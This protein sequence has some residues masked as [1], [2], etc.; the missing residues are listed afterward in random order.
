MSARSFFRGDR[1]I[2]VGEI[3]KL[4]GAELHRNA[5]PARTITGIATLDRGGPSDLAFLDQA[6]DL[7]RA[8]ASAVGACLT[9]RH[10]AAC[11]P[12]H[13]ALLVVEQPFEAFVAV[14]RALFPDALRPS[15]LFSGAHA[16]PGVAAGAVVHPSA[17]LE[18]GVTIDPGAVIGAGAEVGS[19]TTIGANAVIGA[20]VRIGRNCA[21]GPNAS[22][23]H[24]LIG[25]R[26]I[27]H[28]GCRIGQDGFG[29]AMAPNGHLKIP[30]VGRVIVQDD[31]EIGAGSCIDRGG[32]SDTMIGEGSKIDNQVQ[33]GHNT[34]I[35]R[36]CVLVAQVGIA[37]SVVLEDY[38]MLERQVGVADNLTIGE[39][40]RVGAQ[41]EVMSDIP[42]GQAWL[43][44]PAKPV[45]DARGT[46]R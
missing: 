5:D 18:S 38:V 4:T 37:G 44:S 36:H 30:Q 17:R 10:S 25:D 27:L 19:G 28:A 11:V 24:A 2:S 12:A 16:A 6:R 23:A 21:I 8:R 46:V 40:A 41:S 15:S 39:G 33:V 32:L 26:V 9:D 42:A 7:D 20:D 29:F 45:P 31:V 3:A 13:T 34:V 1:R 14:A 35:G 43:G 22:V